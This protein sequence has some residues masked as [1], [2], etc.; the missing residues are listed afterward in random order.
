[1]TIKLRAS[2]RVI[3]WIVLILALPAGVWLRMW[4][5][6]LGHNY[7]MDSWQ[8]VSDLVLQG[9]NVYVNTHR[10]NYGPFWFLILG[11]LRRIHD[12][13]DLSNFGVESFHVVIATFLSLIDFCISTVILRRWGLA[14]AL[15]FFLNP[16]AILLTGAHSQFD[17]LGLLPGL[18]AWLMIEPADNKN[19]TP[20][21]P[22]RVWI[23]SAL[24]MGISL[25]AKHVLIFF[26]FWLLACPAALG[27]LRRRITYVMI[28][29]GVFALILTPFVLEPGALARALHSFV[30]HQYT[31]T[32]L[33]SH[34]V[35]L[36]VPV[37]EFDSAYRLLPT[38]SMLKV[39]FVLCMLGLGAIVGKTR[40]TQLLFCYLLGMLIFTPTLADQ[41]LAVPLLV[42][43]V[44]F[45]R[46]PVWIYIPITAM[47]VE[48]VAQTHRATGTPRPW[49]HSNDHTSFEL[50]Q[51]IAWLIFLLIS[52]T[53]G[54]RNSCRMLA[55]RIRMLLS[56]NRSS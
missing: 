53:V 36:F 46:W 10:Y 48:M 37:K 3:D 13:V 6:S 43:S 55:G 38:V 9:K 44:Y 25:S 11:A 42:C 30:V 41:Y 32:S 15:I 5:A 33:L 1:M 47:L 28:S 27:A 50:H 16:L 45:R 26:P 23:G 51:A 49:W 54:L 40:P 4:M 56:G 14:P 12:A 29:Y 8:I 35:N 22:A 31:P 7:D 20:S 18:I 19:A 34:V 24:L 52:I 17:N 2:I 21:H 39:L